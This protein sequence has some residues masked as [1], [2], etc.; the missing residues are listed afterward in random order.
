[1]SDRKPTFSLPEVPKGLDDLV[2]TIPLR[3]EPSEEQMEQEEPDVNILGSTFRYTCEFCGRGFN[4]QGGYQEHVSTHSNT[5]NYN[6]DVYTCNHCEKQFVNKLDYENHD[7]KPTYQSYNY[8]KQDYYSSSHGA[9]QC[10]VC[11]KSFNQ[12]YHLQTHMA[13]HTGNKPF[14][15]VVCQKSFA[16]KDVLGVHMKVHS[17]VKEFQC[18]VCLARFKQKYHLTRHMNTHLDRV[19]VVCDFCGQVFHRLDRYNQHIKRVHIGK[20]DM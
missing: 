9:Y 5:M 15:C 16:R 1:M 14:T 17:D 19:D 10:S 7:C 13:S 4:S 8:P 2:R 3:N 18:D 11:N 20:S 6:T 12:R